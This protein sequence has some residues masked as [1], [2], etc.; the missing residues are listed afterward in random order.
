MKIIL[1][2]VMVILMTIIL[3]MTMWI[4]RMQMMKKIL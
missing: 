3:K 4:T 2:S 1:V